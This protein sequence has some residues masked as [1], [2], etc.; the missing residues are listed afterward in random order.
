M[1]ADDLTIVT[2]RLL[3]ASPARVYRAWTD[4]SEL[5]Q[6]WGPKG[7]TNTIHV[8]EPWAGG[9]WELTMRAP[10]GT[11][12][13]NL[14]RFQELVANE[15]IV[16]DHLGPMHPFTARIIFAPV[17]E[18]T[19]IEW[20]MAHAHREQY[21]RVIGFVPRANEEN[22]DRLGSLLERDAQL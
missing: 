22:L 8:F 15:R 17:P 21:D 4:P 9:R 3:H 12:F 2:R 20:H 10:D 16:F 11:A 13:P 6:W 18:G 5:E 14:A 7:F 19:F 1:S